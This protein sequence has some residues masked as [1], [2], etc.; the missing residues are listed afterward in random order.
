MLINHMNRKWRASARKLFVYVYDNMLFLAKSFSKSRIGNPMTGHPTRT[1]MLAPYVD[2]GTERSESRVCGAPAPTVA[3]DQ[4]SFALCERVRSTEFHTVLRSG[5]PPS[6]AVYVRGTR[7]PT[8][9][10]IPQPM[11]QPFNLHAN[12]PPLSLCCDGISRDPR[13]ARAP[14]RARPQATK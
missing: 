8:P 14:C 9:A 12:K 1:T 2:D 7:G 6:S 10:A 3:S 5:L 11:P 4:Q 13:A